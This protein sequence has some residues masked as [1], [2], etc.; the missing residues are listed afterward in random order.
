MSRPTWRNRVGMLD[1]PGPA[2]SA[3]GSEGI[4]QAQKVR[5]RSLSNAT[6]GSDRVVPGQQLPEERVSRL[7]RLA[8]P[9]VTHWQFSIVLLAAIVVRIIVILGYP[10]ILWFTDSYNYIYDAVAHVPDRIRPNGYPFFI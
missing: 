6:T 7:T 2:G 3:K 4:R 1:H 5:R 8:R 10:P 9:A